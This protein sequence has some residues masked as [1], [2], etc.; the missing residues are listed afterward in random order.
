MNLLIALSTVRSCARSSAQIRT[1]QG[2]AA[3]R[4]VDKKIQQLLRKKAWRDREPGEPMPVHMHDDSHL[5][6]VPE[7]P[8]VAALRELVLAEADFV[9][10][11]QELRSPRLRAAVEKANAALAA[12]EDELTPPLI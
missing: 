10:S 8:L 3:L 12:L 9:S 7:D 11:L 4:H 1:R 5:Y 6:P 2:R